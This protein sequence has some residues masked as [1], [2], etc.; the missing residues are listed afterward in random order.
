MSTHINAPEAELDDEEQEALDAMVDVD[1]LLE[2]NVTTEESLP[3]AED[4]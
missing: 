2:G 4:R 1:D 3:P